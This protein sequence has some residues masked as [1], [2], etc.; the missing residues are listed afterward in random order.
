MTLTTAPTTAPTFP[1]YPPMTKDEVRQ[2]KTHPNAT[3]AHLALLDPLL[4]TGEITIISRGD[5]A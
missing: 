1:H 4:E 3:P 2:F 5:E